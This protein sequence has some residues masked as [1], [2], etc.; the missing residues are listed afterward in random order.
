[1]TAEGSGYVRVCTLEEVR[2][3]SPR[4]VH[5]A[6]H[7]IALFRHEGRVRAVDNRCP[8]MGFPLSKG[9]VKDGILTCHWHHARFDLCSG[10]TFDPFA[11]DVRVYPV[12]IE[13]SEVWVDA[14]Q[15]SADPAARHRARL[16]DGLRHDLRLVIAKAV[17][18]LAAAGAP[19]RAALEVAADFGTRYASGGWGPGLTILTAMGNILPLLRA[20]DRPRALYQGI[21]HV[22]RE[23]AGQP[24]AFRQ[25]PLATTERR[26]EVFKRW[27]RGFVEMRDRDGAERT[28]RTAVAVG[29]PMPVVADMLFAAAT[30]HRYLDAGHPMDFASKALELLDLIGWEHAEQVLPSVVPRLARAQ[31]AEESSAWRQPVD[32]AAL[33]WAAFEELPAAAARGAAARAPWEGLAGLVETL[34][35]DDPAASVAALVAA[36]GEGAAPEALAQAAACAAARRVAQFHT[37]NEYGDW[38]T[39]LHT[40]TYANAVH[41]AMRRAPSLEL[42]R[43]VF[44]AAMSVYLD[45]FLNTPPAALP[46]P[47]GGETS[48][49][50][51]LE[52]L[53]R[54]QQVNEAARWVSGVLDGQEGAARAMAALGEGLLREDAGFHTFQAVEAAFRQR[55][56]LGDTEEGR[57][58]LVAAARYLAAHSPTPRALGQTYQIALRLHRGE[59]LYEG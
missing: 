59:A 41:Q 52:L 12:R 45:R 49:E 53:D 3:G 38:D 25:E 16:E 29:L 54:Q 24:P 11:D 55:A 40:F 13:G 30:D 37:A 2:E 10:G 47:G 1:M 9:S 6:G 42:L 34:L 8:H 56:L 17:V 20:E 32:L 39:A 58:A 22:A 31:R 33:L 51:L 35:R 26:P 36:L 15:P 44:D 19:E 21:T 23:T 7:T 14:G 27:F 57:V 48:P 50:A 5:A 4:V 28:L 43:G 18:G 46:R